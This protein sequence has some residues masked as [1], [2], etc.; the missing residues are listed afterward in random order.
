MRRGGMR[1]G[2]EQQRRPRDPES[3]K[4]KL[5]KEMN[6]YWLRGG[7]KDHGKKLYILNNT[8]L[9]IAVKDLDNELEEYRKQGDAGKAT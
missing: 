9:Y 3:Y 7:V 6:E 4:N 2:E 5:D 1:G 8:N